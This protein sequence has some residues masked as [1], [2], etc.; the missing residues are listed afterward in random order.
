MSTPLSVLRALSLCAAA[1]VPLLVAAPA[2]AADTESPA[3]ARPTGDP[4][5]AAR[6]LIA[7]KKWGAAIG[8]LERVNAVK[9]ADWNNLMGYSQRKAPTPDLAAAARYYEAALRIDPNHRAALEYSG[10]LFL[11]QNNLAG[12]EQ[13]LA[14]LDKACAGKCEELDDLKAAVA[15]FKTGR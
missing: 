12:A 8:E 9:S 6:K 10:E 1:L 3:A 2:A 13:R 15:R 7:D 4:L 14:A 11:M 5:G